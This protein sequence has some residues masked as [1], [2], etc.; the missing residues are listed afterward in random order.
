MAKK[1]KFDDSMSLRHVP[2]YRLEE[3]LD[4]SI[5]I[6]HGNIDDFSNYDGVKVLLAG[7]CDDKPSSERL[8][9]EYDIKC[10]Y[11]PFTEKEFKPNFNRLVK[12]ENGTTLRIDGYGKGGVYILAKFISYSTFLDRY[13]FDNDMHCGVIK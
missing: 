6:R 13:V 3:N 8:L 2:L 11:R 5:A 10:K 12:N 4:G 1:Y 7:C 9:K